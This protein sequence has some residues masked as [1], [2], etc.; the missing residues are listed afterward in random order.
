MR[1]VA[2]Q[3]VAVIGA[4]TALAGLDPLDALALDE[5]RDAYG[6]HYDIG[7]AESVYCAFWLFDGPMDLLT[8]DT[9]E[10]LDSAIRADWARRT[11]GGRSDA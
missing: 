7:Y 6:T 11:A 2:G 10:G 5:L 4:W 1:E 3:D 9:P 8:A